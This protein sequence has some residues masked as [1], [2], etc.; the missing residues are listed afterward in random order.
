MLIRQ[1]LPTKERSLCFH[2][3]SFFLNFEITPFL[4]ASFV[5]LAPT[6]RSKYL[7][8]RVINLQLINSTNLTSVSLSTTMAPK[9]LL[10]KLPLRL[11]TSSKYL[12]KLL[13]VPTFFILGFPKK[14]VICIGVS[15]LALHHYQQ[16]SSQTSSLKFPFSSFHSSLPQQL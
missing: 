11:D 13:I 8:G 12:N 3:A 15:L 6:G 4:V 7:N 2:L 16:K 10:K 9:E 1:S 5:G 14:C